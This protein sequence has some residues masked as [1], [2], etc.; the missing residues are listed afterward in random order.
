[1]P[2]PK[3]KQMKTEN[4]VVV[5][6]GSAGLATSYWLTR[7]KLDH[8]VIERGD[9]GNTWIK[10]RWDGFHLV[11]PNW[12]LRLPGFHYTGSQPE[13]Y[14][15]KD[16]T[17][18]YLHDY[19]KYFDSPVLTDVAV[20]SLVKKDHYYLLN[21]SKGQNISAR[22]VIIATGAFG[23]P[24]IPDY[25]SEISASIKQMHSSEY[26]NPHTLPRGG[27]LVVGSGQSG[28]QI[29]EE[30]LEAGRK[31]VLSVG[32]AGRRPRRYRGR[33]SSWWNYAMGNFDKTI[34]DVESINKS[35]FGSSAHT[36]GTKGGHDIYLR[37]MAKKGMQLVGSVS[38]ISGNNLTLELGLIK[39]LEKVDDH[40]ITWKKN[41]DEYIE[42]FGI[43]V[44]LDDTVEPSG[45]QQWPRS[46]GPTSFNLLDF[47]IKTI[48]WSTGF[49]YDFDWIKL[50]VTDEYNFPV[51]QRGVTEF[52]GLYFMG[53]QWMYGSKSAQFIGVGED[54]KHVCRHIAG[55]FK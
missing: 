30:L 3:R 32:R 52:P 33:D 29:S 21:T 9:I 1:M 35:R 42:R 11:N 22:C 51:Q 39:T 27:V 36:S 12:A 40:P 54:A 18:A 55:I 50:P 28:A 5:G 34:E 49:K 24:K 44:P 38:G 4:I 19:A 10:E 45:I 14:L 25:A 6:A 15:S 7:M 37:Q 31:V 2:K 8:V 26:K 53:L 20:E 43:K 48:I 17:I 46:D 41:V 47:G 13:G 16:A 23:I